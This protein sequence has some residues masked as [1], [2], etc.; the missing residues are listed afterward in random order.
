MLI[1][2]KPLL[3]DVRNTREP[4]PIHDFFVLLLA[5]VGFPSEKSPLIISLLNQRCLYNHYCT[6]GIQ[7]Y[8]ELDELGQE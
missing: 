4:N 6:T 3:C 8:S 7:I 5:P 2:K 1:L